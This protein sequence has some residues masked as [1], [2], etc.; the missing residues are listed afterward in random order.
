ML[1]PRTNQVVSI[2]D[3]LL[4]QS[5]RDQSYSAR[6]PIPF[7][8]NR[9]FDV[10][11]AGSSSRTFNKAQDMFNV[12]GRP[13]PMKPQSLRSQVEPFRPPVNLGDTSGVYQPGQ[14]V[15]TAEP[16]TSDPTLRAL[17]AEG[18]SAM[19]IMDTPPDLREREAGEAQMRDLGGKAA[20]AALL[21]AKNPDLKEDP[22]FQDRIKGFF[23]DRE[24]MLR[25]ALA[26]NT[27]RLQPDQGLATMLSNELKDLSAR[28]RSLES[29]NKTVVAL[30]ALN[31]KEATQAADMIEA[32]P[33]LAKEIYSAFAANQ[34]KG[35]TEQRKGEG[36]IRK[37]FT[38]NAEVKDFGKQASAFGRVISS[39]QDPSAAGD[40]AL[41]FNYMKVLDP[42][43]TVREGE[44]ATAQNAGGVG[45]RVI[46]LY[47]SIKRGERLSPDQRADFVDRS[48][49]LYLGAEQGYQGIRKQYSDIARQYDYDIDRAV[50]D[51]YEE[52]SRLAN[53][54]IS[55]DQ[56]P[57]ETKARF[58]DAESWNTHFQNLPYLEQLK[59]MRL[60]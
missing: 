11:S 58:G 2:I 17:G 43:S 56:L 13:T 35:P 42:G 31:T 5:N 25:M 51:L 26:F 45:E 28:G 40:L 32:N 12:A 54:Q 21:E 41:I 18:E 37:E 44:F 1:R 49:R 50:P 47:N 4:Q 29:A 34:L 16:V 53:P 52:S 30:R 6:S 9:P 38:G 23:G 8:S 10:G 24:N 48:R 22:T 33:T 3:E 15:P 57:A 19:A 20:Q 55:F 7:P 60:L 46:S 27:M 14:M 36:G 59:L 39:A